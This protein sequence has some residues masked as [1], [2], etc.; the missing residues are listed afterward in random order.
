MA[1]N[2]TTNGKKKSKKGWAIA[3]IVYL[4]FKMITAFPMEY[5]WLSGLLFILLIIFAIVYA[6]R[7]AIAKNRME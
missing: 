2:Q 3:L 1:N 5:A 4:A 6:I 7:Y